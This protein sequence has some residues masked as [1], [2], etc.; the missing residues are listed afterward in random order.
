MIP[1]ARDTERDGLSRT[2]FTEI[3]ERICELD[4]ET[5]AVAL[6]DD[7]GETVDL[8][9]AITAPRAVEPSFLRH[10]AAVAEIAARPLR[11]DSERPTR[12]LS[13]LTKHAQLAIAPLFH[14]YVLVLLRGRHAP[15]ISESHPLEPALLEL[16]REAGWP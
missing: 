14:G 15:P 11:R 8:A 4:G 13:I 2:G 9:F 3:L 6:V 7:D 5:L 16:R 1:L 12:W 10:A